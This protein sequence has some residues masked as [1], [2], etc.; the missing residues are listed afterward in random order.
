MHGLKASVPLVAAVAITNDASGQTVV[1][2]GLGF[3]PG[4]KGPSQPGQAMSAQ[5]S[6]QRTLHGP[7]G[8]MNGAMLA[9]GT[10]LR[11]PPPKA[12]RFA[13]LLAPGQTIA[14]Q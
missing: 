5:G 14:R 12:E 10:I 3:G 1:D 11:L 8:E 13:A 9:D 2:N 7:R 6:V 4:P